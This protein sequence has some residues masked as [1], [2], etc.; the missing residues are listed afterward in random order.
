VS[1]VSQ[2]RE[3]L[4]GFFGGAVETAN[5]QTQA[6]IR[7]RK[8]T[9]RS[10][11]MT[12]ILGLLRN[13]RAS[14]ADLAAAAAEAGADVSAQAIENRFTPIGINLRHSRVAR[15]PLTV[16]AYRVCGVDCGGRSA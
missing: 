8:F 12:F 10:L 1:I 16:P 2:V 15:G 4:E 7:R 3:T 5:Q 6:V 14:L 13:P 11:A 9:A